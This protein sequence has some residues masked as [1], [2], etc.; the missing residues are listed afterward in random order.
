MNTAVR[1]GLIAAMSLALGSCAALGPSEAPPDTFEISSP[2]PPQNATSRSRAQIL[3][4]EPTA[5]RTLDSDNILVKTT[6]YTVEYLAGGQWSDRLTRMVQLR[7]LQ[8]FENSGRVGAVG[9]PGQGLAIDYQIVMELRR[10]EI[11]VWQG[12][13]A[14]IEISVKA[15]NDR[16]G[17]VRASRVFQTSEPV[18]GGSNEERIAAMD[19]AFDRISH[20]IVDWALAA[21]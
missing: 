8:A 3:I 5:L 2:E 6:P 14:V 16:D 15:L 19:R 21:F 7:M 9:V 11:A 12:N 1:S 20:Q 10:F 17:Q 18:Q 4:A 13:Q